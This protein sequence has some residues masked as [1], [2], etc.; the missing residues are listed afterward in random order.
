MNRKK[1]LLNT[2]SA[3]PGLLLFPQFITAQ[4]ALQQTPEPYKLDVVKEFVIAGHGGKDGDFAKV[5][6]ML[7]DYPNLIYSK[8]D[9]GNGDYEGAIEGAGHMGKKELASYLID[10][11]SRITL[12]VLTMLGKTELV[13]P[14]LEQ[15]PKLIFAKGP[16]GFTMLHH[17]KMGGKEGEELYTY[18]QDKGLKETWIKIK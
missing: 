18:L 11:G 10:A 14:I 6:S 1:F 13:K 8:Y 17:A 4:Q 3:V 15:Y 12:F 7:K 9:W 16:H 5:Q 2:A